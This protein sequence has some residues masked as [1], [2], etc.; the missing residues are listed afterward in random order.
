MNP[1]CSFTVYSGRNTD[2]QVV[3]I[4]YGI[5]GYWRKNDSC[6]GFEVDFSNEEN[7]KVAY[8]APLIDVKSKDDYIVW[9]CLENADGTKFLQFFFSVR[10]AFLLPI[11][12]E[13][14]TLHLKEDAFDKKT[15]LQCY[16]EYLEK[17]RP[18]S[19]IVG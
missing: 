13:S 6:D 5:G 15:I 10:Y 1:P 3:S 18:E 4:S 7:L 17:N 19:K 9:V 14:S 8:I 16:E 12:K 11:K 2:K